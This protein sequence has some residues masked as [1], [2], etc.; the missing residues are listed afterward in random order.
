MEVKEAKKESKEDKQQSEGKEL[1]LAKKTAMPFTIYREE[2]KVSP[3]RIN[4]E[5]K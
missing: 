4:L 5:D 3:K 1:D 2:S